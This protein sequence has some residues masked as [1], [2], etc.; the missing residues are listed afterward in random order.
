MSDVTN[1][2]SQRAGSMPVTWSR[3]FAVAFLL[4][5]AALGPLRS[6]I[7]PA[8]FSQMPGTSA[9]RRST[10]WEG[11]DAGRAAGGV[12]SM[13]ALVAAA[14]WGTRIESAGSDAF[15]GEV[16]LE[17]AA[18]DSTKLV[19]PVS[20]CTSAPNALR[21][22]ALDASGGTLG[23]WE[24]PGQDFGIEVGHWE[25]EVPA[26]TARVEL[27]LVDGMPGLGGWLGVGR[28]SPATEAGRDPVLKPVLN[29]GFFLAHAVALAGFLFLPG[30]AIRAWTRAFVLP[31]ALLPIPGFALASA[32]GLAVWLAGP[33]A[34]GGLAIAYKIA[35]VA[36][37]VLVIARRAP[38]HG[39]DER[40]ALRIYW[41]VVVVVI[42]W[43]IVPLTVEK[44]FFAGTNARGRMVASPPDCVIP[45]YT[46]CYFINDSDGGADPLRY[47]GHEWTATSRGPLSAWVVVAALTVFEFKPHEPPII[48]PNAWPAD[49]EGHFLSRI[50]GIMTNALVVL[51]AFVVL[52][53]FAPGRRDLLWFGLGWVA[54]SPIVMINTAFLWPKMLATYFGLLAIAEVAGKR[55]S[56]EAALWL[57]LSYLAH[58]VGVLIAA[59]VIVWNG[60]LA[61]R[62]P[63]IFRVRVDLFFGR[64]M[65]LGIWM[66]VFA[67]PWLLFKFLEGKHD[68]FFRYPLGDGRGFEMA[69]SV[70]SWITCRLDNI[71][72]SLVPGTLWHSNLLVAWA[73][74]TLSMPAHWAMNCAKTLPFGVGIAMFVLLLR[75]MPVRRNGTLN[76]FRIWVLGGGF[77]LMVLVW[78]FSRDGLGRNCLEP[79]IVF[80]ILATAA[81]MPR[82]TIFA[83]V[84]TALLALEAVALLVLAYVANPGFRSATAPTAAWVLIIVTVAAWGVLAWIALSRPGTE[85]NGVEKVAR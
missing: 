73:G 20:G 70:T 25:F 14:L 16:R 75:W 19:L 59:P 74:G 7:F 54:L 29:I 81:V 22:Q 63:M 52:Q 9:Q 85:L 53:V 26:G 38:P 76:A 1:P 4:A 71:W 80:A 50:A 35:H 42:V 44:E 6:V 27:T 37:A 47:F 49:R 79:L 58:P 34:A 11:P 10:G 43:S 55:R 17:G 2:D 46:A 36:F 45:F 30:I 57:A 3:T 39:A 51:G 61:A 82:V 5:L 15:T 84:L 8:P 24:H 12:F 78:G 56:P 13:D 40:H 18:P 41:A 31:L 69:A 23:E 28:L 64:S 77:L 33:S 65:W 83:R 66:I 68:V 62:G 48:A 60:M 32:T 21:A 72:Y 67:S